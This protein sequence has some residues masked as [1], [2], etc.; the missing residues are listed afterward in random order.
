[1]RLNQKSG[2]LEQRES[3][4]H[5]EPET[6][7]LSGTNVM[8]TKHAGSGFNSEHFKKCFTNSDTRINASQNEFKI[9]S[10]HNSTENHL[11]LPY[12]RH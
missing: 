9:E 5:K 6:Q 7:K 1:M 4:N 8:Y 11:I 12:F 10:H 2:C 3:H